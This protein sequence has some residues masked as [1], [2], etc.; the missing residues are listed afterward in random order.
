MDCLETTAENLFSDGVDKQYIRT[1]ISQAPFHKSIFHLFL[2]IILEFRVEKVKRVKRVERVKKGGEGGRTIVSIK[3]F[4]TFL[5]T[6]F[7]NNYICSGKRSNSRIT[8]L[9]IYI[10]VH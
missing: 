8:L 10:S 5:G 3:I 6:Y 1:G 4:G 2:G 7:E 9:P